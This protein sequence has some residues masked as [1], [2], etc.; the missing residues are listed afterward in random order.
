MVATQQFL[1]TLLGL[2]LLSAT[3]GFR[4]AGSFHRP[5]SSLRGRNSRLSF[6]PVQNMPEKIT[7]Q[8]SDFFE[9][10]LQ[11]NPSMID[12][13]PI[14]PQ[15]LSA[16]KEVKNILRR[17]AGKCSHISSECPQ[18]ENAL[19]S[20]CEEQRESHLAEGVNTLSYNDAN[21]FAGKWRILT[22]PISGVN[23]IPKLYWR[24]TGAKKTKSMSN[25]S[26]AA[27]AK[28]DVPLTVLENRASVKDLTWNLFQDNRRDY[29]LRGQGALVRSSIL[30]VKPEYASSTDHLWPAASSDEESLSSQDLKMKLYNSWDVSHELEIPT[31]VNK[32]PQEKSNK[33]IPA[34]L[35]CTYQHKGYIWDGENFA[36]GLRETAFEDILSDNMGNNKVEV[37]AIGGKLFPSDTAEDKVLFSEVFTHDPNELRPLPE[38]KY[39]APPPGVERED[40]DLFREILYVSKNLLVFKVGGRT[41]VAE[42]IIVEEP[43]TPVERGDDEY[44][45]DGFG[46]SSPDHVI[47]EGSEDEHY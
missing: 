46:L 38:K 39:Y 36:G 31:F 28:S 5:V 26:A 7:Q 6:M 32:S 23:G 4:P 30:E 17:N 34:T 11:Q 20:L 3:M 40:P 19:K 12:N 16:E 29:G 24:V 10:D 25:I 37:G 47:E 2:L 18:L 22:A 1:A 35:H 13:L 45:Y 9:N 8:I 21:L 15:Q 43:T 14:S 27:L 33:L 44:E 41:V 42:R